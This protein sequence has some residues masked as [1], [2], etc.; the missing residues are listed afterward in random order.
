MV[1]YYKSKGLTLL[2]ALD[3]IFTRCGVYREALH[4]IDL[5]GM[6][7]AQQSAVLMEGLAA[8]PP[9]TIAGI[10]VDQ[11]IDYHAGTVKQ[12]RGEEL[13]LCGKTVFHPEQTLQFVLSDGTK[14]SVRPS[15]TE[16][17][18]KIYLAVVDKRRGL[19]G[20]ALLASKQGLEEKLALLEGAL[21]TLLKI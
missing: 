18:V 1:A 5:P 10:S 21:A 19:Q 8:N 3:E 15:G 7:G 17:K 6:A 14:L 9:R 12:W 4:S 11:V 16:P 2:A 20:A 13:I